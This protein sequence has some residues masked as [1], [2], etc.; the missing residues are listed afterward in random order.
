MA[1]M[2]GKVSQTLPSSHTDVVSGTGRD[3][4]EWIGDGYLEIYMR[5]ETLRRSPSASLDHLSVSFEK[6]SVSVA[7]NRQCVKVAFTCNA[8]LAELYTELDLPQLFPQIPAVQ[9]NAAP[10]AK[11]DFVETAIG[12]LVV[13]AGYDT[14]RV[15]KE[16]FDPVFAQEL[17]LKCD[18]LNN[19]S[20]DKFGLVRETADLRREQIT[21]H[22]QSIG[23]RCYGTPG[24]AKGTPYRHW[25]RPSLPQSERIDPR[26]LRTCV[27]CINLG[28]LYICQTCRVQLSTA[29][30]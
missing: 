15:K 10:K 6:G 29:E 24:R 30:C 26:S 13:A 12:C 21:A 2:W 14:Q 16:F 18:A 5:S 25:K 28:C 7:D 4:L 8:W 22:K 20:F 1:S 11:A 17:S 19:G 9:P 23:G 27:C 3:R